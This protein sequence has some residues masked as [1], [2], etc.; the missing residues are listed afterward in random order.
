MEPGVSQGMPMFDEAS[1]AFRIPPETSRGIATTADRKDTWPER[2]ELLGRETMKVELRMDI[3]ELRITP[4]NALTATEGT[5]P[6]IPVSRRCVMTSK[7]SRLLSLEQTLNLSRIR[8][9][10]SE[11]RENISGGASESEQRSP[12]GGEA[13]RRKTER[14]AGAETS[15]SCG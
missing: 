9:T 2:A 3:G 10:G 13:Q 7:D 12:K 4:L 8:E 11:V 15:S 6:P 5:T 14:I 1:E